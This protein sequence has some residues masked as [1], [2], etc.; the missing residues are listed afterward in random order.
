MNENNLNLKCGRIEEY[1][2]SY[3]PDFQKEGG[4]YSLKAYYSDFDELG[5]EYNS[6]V[7]LEN[8][9]PIK[10]FYYPAIASTSMVKAYDYIAV[11]LVE[12]YPNQID[13]VKY[14]EEYHSPEL[15]DEGLS[16]THTP[17]EFAEKLNIKLQLWEID[18]GIKYPPPAFQKE[19][20]PYSLKWYKMDNKYNSMV[21]LEN[22]EKIKEFY[23]QGTVYTSM[24]KA[25]DYIA[26]NL[27]EKYPNQIDLVKY[28]E[29]YHSPEL[30]DEGLSY[31]HTPEEFAER[32][33][34]ELHPWEEPLE[35]DN[36][37]E[38]SASYFNQLETNLLDIKLK[39]CD[40]IDLRLN[41]KKVI[42]DSFKI[43][44]LL[45]KILPKNL[46][47]EKLKEI[48]T[49]L[50]DL[51][52][53]VKNK[54]IQNIQNVLE[55]SKFKIEKL[56]D[57]I[58]ENLNKSPKKTMAEKYEDIRANNPKKTDIEIDIIATKQL[59]KDGHSKI[60]IRN[61]ITK[62]SP[63]ALKSQKPNAYAKN[64]IDK[65]MTPE[66]KKSLNFMER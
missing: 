45:K 18:T 35:F 27:V 30:K 62:L 55:N 47:E 22:G 59:L 56:N 42:K 12:K 5:N 29:E 2:D 48:K 15:K 43:A 60:T 16:Y 34:I 1:K 61:T 41:I 36:N 21:V 28:Q 63:E 23:P 3:S 9:K 38:N 40:Q 50:N 4:P 49:L 20:G 46:Q 25:Y 37:Y 6:K 14:Q 26:E 52:K 58:K 57:F 53:A 31:T 64:L 65:A 13:L 10:E 39:E 54:I 7:V 51:Q 24:I 32:L 44:E 17:E 11:N 19:T 33:R 66:F 8:G